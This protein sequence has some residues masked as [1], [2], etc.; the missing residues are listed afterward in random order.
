MATDDPDS[1]AEEMARL[2]VKPLSGKRQAPPGPR[3]DAPAR[4]QARPQPGSTVSAPPAPARGAPA[5]TASDPPAVASAPARG[6]PAVTASGPP[7][8]ASAPDSGELEALRHAAAR[9]Q[10]AQQTLAGERAEWQRERAEWQRERAE[11]QRE[12]ARYEEKNRQLRHTIAEAEKAAQR[13]TRLA[14]LLRERGCA[15]RDEAIAVVRGLMDRRPDEL[16]DAI[17]LTA[18]EPLA[19]ILD[20]R[21]AFVARDLDID[22]GA[23]SVIVR[24]P[25]E[26]CEI[27]GGSDIQAGF[28]QFL[29]ACR[30]SGV[31]RLTIVGG[32]PA[33]R[34]ELVELAAPYA[35]ELKLNLV[36]GTKRRERKRAEAD[37]RT[38]DIVV[39]WGATELD[40]SVSAVYT[41]GTGNVLTVRHRGISRMLSQVA[42]HLSRESR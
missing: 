15:D 12:R 4:Q 6:A 1:F 42:E 5:V 32:S 26:R 41:Q 40:H 37:K 28:R 29:D 20:E 36:S 13:H 9:A 22:L 16:I 30:R 10:T 18:S 3:R 8:V 24:V 27:T 39:I 14:D 2:G 31:R 7:A 21:V 19:Q 25:A 34:R 35:R 11:W 33:Y 23:E 38:S 17:E